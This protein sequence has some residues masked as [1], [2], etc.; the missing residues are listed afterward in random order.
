MRGAALL[1]ETLDVTLKSADALAA[2]T[3]LPVLSS[4]TFDKDS[5]Q[6]PLAAGAAGHSARA[7]AALGSSSSPVRC[8]A[9]A[10]LLRELAAGYEAVIVD[11]APLL[12]VA[13]T[14]ALAALA[15]GALLVVRAG[16]TPRDRV[17][18]ATEAEP[19]QGGYGYGDPSAAQTPPPRPCAEEELSHGAVLLR[20]GVK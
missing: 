15:H 6:Q 8:P 19:R 20:G 18:A 10:E 2:L 14:V 16:K 11:T 13:D 9:K 3:G 4:I 7:E 12:P 5:P 1:R 17:A